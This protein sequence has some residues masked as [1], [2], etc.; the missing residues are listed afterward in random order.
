MKKGAGWQ[1]ELFSEEAM[2]VIETTR[3]QLVIEDAK[4]NGYIARE[5]GRTTKE[6]NINV[7]IGS[8]QICNVPMTELRDDW[9]ETSYR[10]DLLQA[11][12]DCVEAERFVMSNL[13]TP[14]PAKLTFE[15]VKTSFKVMKAIDKPKVAILRSPGTNGDTEMKA[16]FV[17]AGFEVWDVHINAIISGKVSLKMFRGVVWAGGFSYQDVFD[18]GKIIAGIIRFNSRLQK[19]FSDFYNREDTFSLGVCNGAQIMALLGWG[20]GHGLSD[21]QKPRFLHNHSGRFESRFSWVKIGEGPSIMLKGMAGSILGV[22]SAHGEG[23][24]DVPSERL[25]RKI[26]DNGL[27]PIR[28]VD[29]DGNHT[30]TYPFNPNGSRYGITSLCSPDGRH[31][32]M[33]PHPE[34]AFLKYQ[35]PWLP[36]NMKRLKT[37]P[38]LRMA[39][40]AYTWCISTQSRSLQ[41]AA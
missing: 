7:K 36:E 26:M 16:F 32:S 38:W 30:S 6:N 12:P 24:L 4:A 5:I 34:R 1:K 8:N 29:M 3:P 23:C 25:L 41:R 31:L 13:L 9:D 27:A 19:E 33:M 14:P 40:N 37:M 39:Q 20:P 15:P 21:L 11:N 22:W 17:A 28:F 35:Q 2:L 10:M 18:S